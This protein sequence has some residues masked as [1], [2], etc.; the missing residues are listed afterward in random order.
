MRGELQAHW[1]LAALGDLWTG[2]IRPPSVRTFARIFASIDAAAFN[3][4]V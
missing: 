3:A 2:R 4:A 1:L